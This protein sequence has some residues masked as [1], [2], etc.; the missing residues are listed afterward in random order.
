MASLLQPPVN[1]EDIVST[2][3]NDYFAMDDELDYIDDV[4][5]VLYSAEPPPPE[6]G[7]PFLPSGLEG[8]SKPML[9]LLHLR[10]DKNRPS[11]P[12]SI[13]FRAIS[14][15]SK[16]ASLKLRS[17]NGTTAT[18]I[19]PSSDL[20][21]ET[22][23]IGP[24]NNPAQDLPQRGRSS[25]RVGSGERANAD[26]DLPPPVPPKAPSRN[27]VGT[28]EVGLVQT[29]DEMG[30]KLSKTA[31]LKSSSAV[32]DDSMASQSVS[33]QLKSVLKTRPG[34]S[35]GRP[36]LADTM[37]RGLRRQKPEQKPARS[38]LL[39]D[40]SNRITSGQ[41]ATQP[42]VGTVKSTSTGISRDTAP[43]VAR[44]ENTDQTVI[45]HKSSPDHQREPSLSAGSDSAAEDYV[46]PS[47]PTP[48]LPAAISLGE[49]TS[50]DYGVSCPRSTGADTPPGDAESIRQ[51]MH[52]RGKSST[53][54]DIFRKTSAL[55][56]AQAYLNKITPS[57]SISPSSSPNDILPPRTLHL[58]PSHPVL[59][60]SPSPRQT[61]Q[62]YSSQATTIGARTSTFPNLSSLN[63]S[64]PATTT[65]PPLTALH[66]N[67]FHQ[68]AKF[69]I[70]RNTYA[71]VPCMLCYSEGIEERYSCAWCA[72]RICRSCR[73]DLE[74]VRGRDLGIFVMEGTA[75]LSKNGT[76]PRTNKTGKS[77]H[78]GKSGSSLGMGMRLGVRNGNRRQ[79]Q[80]GTMG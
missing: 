71:P 1:R 15:S 79:S 27:Q 22:V 7:Q 2:I 72:L 59:S 18:T 3:L 67:C 19:L 12:A 62:N 14:R 45:H 47:P 17:S 80:G 6:H 37:A 77:G 78:S 57:P 56:S 41:S 49:D 8:K 75:R 52:S 9:G 24:A 25:S 32:G 30:N 76:T 34:T 4:S 42:A 69:H 64:R 44:T 70:S 16:P 73:G 23:D 54:L 63:A 68:H 26:R 20:P 60:P 55:N 5:P 11:S 58:S 28:S 50:S 29:L 10:V 48:V 46:P 39:S 21:F 40:I 31:S 53:G 66:V 43:S 51:G 74:S 61:R 36:T 35:A 65:A 33:S 13:P 38:S